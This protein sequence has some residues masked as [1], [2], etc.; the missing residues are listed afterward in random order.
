MTEPKHPVQPMYLA[1]DG[2]YRFK[3]NEIVVALMEAAKEG[4]KLDLNMIATMNFSR[5]DRVQF[6]QLIGYSQS[7]FADLSYVSD[8]DY[9]KAQTMVR[10][11]KK[12]TG[13]CG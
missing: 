2:R 10:R 11:L 7:G 12:E 6:A 3:A 5:E 4:R 8:R 13:G 9:A 1:E